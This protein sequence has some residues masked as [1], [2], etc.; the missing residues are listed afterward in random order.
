M[1]KKQL[2]PCVTFFP[3][4]ATLVAT[5]DAE[6]RSNLMMASWAGIVSKTPPTMAVSLHQSRRTS[7][8]IG[9]TKMF[10]INLVPSRLVVAA[11]FCGIVSGNDLDKDAVTGLHVEDS[12]NGVP[13]LVESPLS[14]ECHLSQVITLGDYQLTLGKIVEIHA[15]AAAFDAKGQADARVFDP[16]VY[17]GGLREYWSLGSKQADAYRAG[18]KYKT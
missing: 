2:G 13:L 6:G 7:A 10:S 9:A 14:V 5:R 8:N 12:D 3:Q 11:D 16:L 1:E 15:D 18:L 4:P 17:L